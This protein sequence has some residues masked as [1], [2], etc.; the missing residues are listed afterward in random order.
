MTELEKLRNELKSKET[1]VERL[2]EELKELRIRYD[3]RCKQSCGCNHF[4]ITPYIP[5]TNTYG[6]ICGR[7]GAIIRGNHYC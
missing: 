7:C 3:E 6:N 1:Q 2:L 5:Q 4:P